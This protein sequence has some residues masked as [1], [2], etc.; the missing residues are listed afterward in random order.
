[1]EKRLSKIKK[2]ATLFALAIA[3]F[4]IIAIIFSPFSNHKGWEGRQIIHT[5]TINAPVEAIFNY[6]GNSDNARNWSVYVDH[7]TTTNTDKIPD[8]QVGSERRCF[9]EKDETGIIWDERITEV[10]PNIKRQ[11]IIYNLQGFPMV[12][13]NLATEQLYKKINKKQTELSFTLFYKDGHPTYWETFKTYL[14][15]HKIKSIFRQNMDNIRSIIEDE[16]KM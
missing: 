2:I 9:V 4:L 13:N 3:V 11:L 16:V 7:I 1:M 15:A 10:V 14:A 12:A 8:G 6:L 5:V